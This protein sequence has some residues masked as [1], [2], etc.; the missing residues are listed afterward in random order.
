M[1]KDSNC[2]VCWNALQPNIAISIWQ[3]S[4]SFHIRDR[5]D[6]HAYATNQKACNDRPENLRPTQIQGRQHAHL[7]GLY[8]ELQGC[9]K[10]FRQFVSAPNYMKK[11]KDMTT[12]ISRSRAVSPFEN[13]RT[14]LEDLTWLP[15]PHP[16]ITTPP[17]SWLWRGRWTWYPLE[18]GQDSQI[19]WARW[20]D[21]HVKMLL[22]VSHFKL[23]K[24]WSTVFFKFHKCWV[25]GISYIVGGH[26]HSL[27]LV[28]KDA[29]KW[30][31]FMVSLSICWTIFRYLRMSEVAV[32]T[33]LS[34]WDP[35]V[36]NCPVLL[37]V[38][39]E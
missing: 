32:T 24:C 23:R 39:R 15:T 28:F 1:W 34:S 12:G 22:C 5:L 8:T 4:S 29:I 2:L 25:W 11:S 3:L 14:Q 19:T 6:N 7:V 35:L 16:H 9:T 27:D 38:T 21:T 10:G 33:S 18:T 37:E 20:V 31:R 13:A 36:T 26:S 30:K 17:H